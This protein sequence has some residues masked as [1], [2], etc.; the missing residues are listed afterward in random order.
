MEELRLLIE[1]SGAVTVI[2]EEITRLADSARETVA[3]ASTLDPDA[4]AALVDLVDVAT[5][6]TA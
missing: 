3:T 1:A 6:R 4:A 2:E 5:A